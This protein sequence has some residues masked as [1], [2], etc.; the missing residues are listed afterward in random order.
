[1]FI[2]F[3]SRGNFLECLYPAKESFNGAA[4]LVK[5]R[6]EP[7]WPSSFWVY[8]GSPVDR[9]VALFVSSGCTGGSPVNRRQDR[10][11]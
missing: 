11:R 8:P 2:A 3:I 10:L 9:D 6:I 4:L 1:M 7:E 5:F